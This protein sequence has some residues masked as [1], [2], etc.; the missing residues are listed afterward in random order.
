MTTRRDFLAALGLG[1][2]MVGLP[3]MA[4][5]W[6][7]RCRRA[8]QC[9]IEDCDCQKPMAPAA[10]MPM[11]TCSCACPFALVSQVWTTHGWSYYYNCNCCAG[12]TVIAPSYTV[13]G[14]PWPNCAAPANCIGSG[15]SRS[16]GRMLVDEDQSVYHGFLLDPQMKDADPKKRHPLTIYLEGITKSLADLK[17]P[18]EFGM[19]P[20]ATVIHERRN[21]ALYDIGAL[22]VSLGFEVS[23]KV[24]DQGYDD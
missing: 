20:S 23:D 15:C 4:H 3:G 8:T 12:G 24:T 6:G 22:P 11:T 13:Y 7:R 19:D 10:M 9:V 18:E 5:A 1:A 17:K 16:P 14:F 21:L 2:G